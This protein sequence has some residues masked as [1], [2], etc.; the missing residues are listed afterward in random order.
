MARVFSITLFSKLNEQ[1]PIILTQSLD[2]SKFSFWER[3]TVK[4]CLTFVSREM[5]QRTNMVT[6]QTVIY[7]DYKCTSYLTA[8][9]LGCVVV[10]DK[11]YVVRITCQ[12]INKVIEAFLK[13]YENKWDN[14]KNDTSL[15]VASIKMLL[16]EYQD[17]TKVDII[18]KIE[19]D[20]DDTKVIMMKNIE[21]MLDNGEKIEDLVAKTHDLSEK[22]KDFLRISKKLNRCCIVL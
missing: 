4:E 21:Q 1:C 2:L 9:G 13:E 14:I 20:L 6:Y 10:T 17:V 8:K 3:G 11:D 19:Q 16:K 12:L 7:K 5:I 22:S 15:E 18:T